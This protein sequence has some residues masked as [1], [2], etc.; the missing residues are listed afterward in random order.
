MN[1]FLSSIVSWLRAG[2]PEGVPPTDSFAVLALLARRL[3]NDEVKAVA[4]ELMKRGEF[5]QIDIGV[6]ITQF[7]DE[8]PAPEDIERVRTRL[9]TKGWPLDDAREDHT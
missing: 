3:T 4:N 6:V 9:A 5:D 7:T 1:R 8:L 2:Y